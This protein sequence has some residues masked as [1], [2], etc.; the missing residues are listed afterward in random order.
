MR[1]ALITAGN[2]AQETRSA[3]VAEGPK[4][5]AFEIMISM[6]REHAFAASSPF[7]LTF[8]GE[9]SASRLE[10]PAAQGPDNM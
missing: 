4:I 7:V 5:P 2:V 9:V 3:F 8:N 1:V 6:E 10:G